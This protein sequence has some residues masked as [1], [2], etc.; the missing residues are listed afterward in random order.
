MWL[1]GT[2]VESDFH[3]VRFTTQIEVPEPS[4]SLLLVTA[5]GCIGALRW[6]AGSSGHGIA[7]EWR[8]SSY[9]AR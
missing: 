9:P 7:S 5:L 8:R 3:A 2:L 1:G 6:L 4:H